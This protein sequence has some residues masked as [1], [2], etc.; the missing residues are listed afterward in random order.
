MAKTDE[1]C[2]RCLKPKSSRT[3]GFVTQWI[4]V[5]S[6][7]AIDSG[8]NSTDGASVVLC[9][10]CGKRISTGRKGTITQ[11][12]FR[13]DACVCQ[14][15]L[16]LAPSPA[17]SQGDI[18][19]EDTDYEE[20]EL[21][22]GSNSFP[23]ERYAPLAMLGQGA[24]GQVHL[25]RDR[26]LRKKVAVKTLNLLE[27]DAAV[28]FQEEARATSRLD[29]PGIVRVLDFGVTTSGV[30]YMVMDY[31][32]GQ[33]L[34]GHIR[35][36]GPLE[37]ETALL[38]LVRL[39]QALEYSHEQGVFHRDLKPENILLIDNGDGTLATRLI[40]FGLAAARQDQESTFVQG[41]TLV[42]T[43][44]YM[45]PDQFNGLVFDARS[46]IYSLGC[47][48][49]ESIVGRPPFSGG[50]ALETVMMHARQEAPL[51]SEALSDCPEEIEVLYRKCLAKD[52]DDR[53]QSM[54]DLASAL[55]RM[56]YG[57]PAEPETT[58]RKRSHLPALLAACFL[59]FLAI[60]WIA[61]S[62]HQ[63]PV[64]TMKGSNIKG[65]TGRSRKSVVP[66]LELRRRKVFERLIGHKY[67]GYSSTVASDDD[68]KLLEGTGT[69][70]LMLDSC[71]ITAAGLENLQ[72]LP[73]RFL[74][75]KYS[76]LDDEAITVI[77]KFRQL[78]HLDVGGE[79]I[80][81]RGFKSL[82]LPVLRVLYVDECKG[83]NDAA[84]D[85]IIARYP[86]LTSINI[87][88]TSVT[89][90]GISR[91]AALK[92]LIY[93]D[94]STLPVSAGNIRDLSAIALQKIDLTG[95]PMT[96][97]ALLEL[98]R[99]KTLTSIALSANT[100]AD[101]ETLAAI[102]R[103]FPPGQLDIA[104]FISREGK[105]IGEAATLSDFLGPE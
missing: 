20:Q 88:S 51:L 74:S 34:A 58:N 33:S 82:D 92:H 103:A 71:R 6:C 26:L 64:Q 59:A 99:I 83:F 45:S 7:D 31:F 22:L 77:N 47:V 46:E 89:E 39:V 56:L 91:L 55:E 2:F 18:Q 96:S 50:T 61:L 85:A 25:C 3:S 40:D 10:E 84:L 63:S 79:S 19:P 14:R 57:A 41:R 54:S 8:E 43:P 27:P 16:G 80:T 97:Q 13:A 73:L 37:P 32:P 90:S 17:D 5:C 69:R 95:C 28:A 60:G 15:P 38:L 87:A 72:D 78:K 42:G 104:N 81:E 11:Y 53:F 67:D 101:K 9:R 98:R 24:G 102:R 75:I 36:N 76:A 21:D 94:L 12:V 29:H 4:S 65:R 44:S 49:F 35:H 93:L 86:D 52:P 68:L 70:Q 23:V 66:D 100:G 1:I 48:F 105:D 62:F 30:P